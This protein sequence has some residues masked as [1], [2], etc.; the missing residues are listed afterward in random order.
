MYRDLVRLEN[1]GLLKMS[2]AITTKKNKLF[3]KFCNSFNDL[4]RIIRCD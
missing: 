3:N 4:S 2:D 1:D